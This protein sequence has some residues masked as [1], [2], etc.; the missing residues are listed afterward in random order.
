MDWGARDGR[1]VEEYM[2]MVRPE[3]LGRVLGLVPEG[4]GYGQVSQW[5]GVGEYL[6][7]YLKAVG[8]GKSVSG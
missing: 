5:V 1:I 3:D 8:M 4:S 7:S 2:H 6:A